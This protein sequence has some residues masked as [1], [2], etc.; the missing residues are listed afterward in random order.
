MLDMGRTI[1][2]QSKSQPRKRQH[3]IRMD[4]AFKARIHEYQK[5]E[6]ERVGYEVTF[7]AVVR[8]LIEKGLDA[9]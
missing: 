4:D 8:K 9:Y 7:S 1:T 5:S 2:G 3:Q 6:S